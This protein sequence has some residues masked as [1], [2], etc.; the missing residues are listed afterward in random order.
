[1]LS[2]ISVMR[3]LKHKH[4][5]ELYEVYEMDGHLAMVMEYFNKGSVGQ[6][7]A[8]GPIPEKKAFSILR[9]V[10]EGLKYMHSRNLVHRDIKPG[11]IM[12]RDPLQGEGNEEIC[13]IID[14]GLCASLLDKS[15]EALIH[16]KSGTVGYLAPEII[17]KEGKNTFYNERV[18]IF[19]AGIV[20]YEM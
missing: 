7:V 18:D 19:S 11:N 5:A 17:T 8:K 14:F 12:L 3:E 4:L 2:E 15:D 6:R 20:F 1:M 13:K 10:L 9:M 16:D